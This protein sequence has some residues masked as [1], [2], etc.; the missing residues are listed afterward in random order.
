MC[1]HKEPR[2]KGNA[3]GWY[4]RCEAQ[5]DREGLVLEGFGFHMEHSSLSGDFT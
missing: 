2:K 4:R 5:D 1:L 3:V